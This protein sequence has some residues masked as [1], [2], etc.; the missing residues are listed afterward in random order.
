MPI[1]RRQFNTAAGMGLALTVLGCEK[2]PD[3]SAST[4]PKV[5][6][7]TEPFDAGPLSNYV[8][9]GIYDQ[10]YAASGVVLISDGQTLIA[11]NPT[12]T[13]SGCMTEWRNAD[14]AFVCD[15]HGSRFD[16]HGQN[17]PG[18]K[19]SQ[20]LKRCAIGVTDRDGESMVRIDPT[21]MFTKEADQWADPA[22][23]VP[24]EQG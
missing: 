21:K 20:P 4:R 17:Q 3:R 8:E 9:K 5:K 22:S 2:K 1:S 16:K 11:V 7:A 10:H 12:C 19:A 14:D 13:H 23:F 18:S 6:L 24:L 15:C